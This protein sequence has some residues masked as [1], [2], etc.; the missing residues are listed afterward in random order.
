MEDSFVKGN[1]AGV[2]LVDLTAAYDTVLHQELVLKL[3]YKIP[4]RH[5][6]RFLTKILADR[7]FVPKTS[8]RNSSHHCCLRNAVPQGSCLST[9]LFNI[10]I[11]DIPKTKSHLYGYADDLALLHSNKIWHIVEVRS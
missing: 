11:S 4:D 10:Y 8:D 9:R 5:M 1:K 2:I 3:L 6:V 7:T